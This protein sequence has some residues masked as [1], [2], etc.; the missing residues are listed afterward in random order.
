MPAKRTTRS[1]RPRPGRIVIDEVTPALDGGA[2]PIKRVVGEPVV[3]DATI[4]ADGH[5]RL[6]CVV[7]HQPPGSRSW[8][9]A[10]MHTT[11][12]GLD[13]WQGS[14]TPSGVG[15]H[16]YRV[17][18]WIDELASWADAARRKLDDNQE[19][20]S[21]LLAGAG[22]VEQ[23]SKVA[24]TE[25]RVALQDAA[26]R[27]RGG[28]SNVVSEVGAS[29]DR[30]PDGASVLGAYR[31]GF[32]AAAAATS[33][34]TLDVRVE[35]D[36]AVFNTWYELFPRSW[37]TTDGQHGTFKDVEAQL[38]Y[39][40]DLG[41]DVLYLPPIHPIG[42]SFRKGPG[43]RSTGGPDDPGSPWAIGSPEG[44]HTSI[45]PRLGTLDDFRRLVEAARDNRLDIA[46]D[47]AF[48]CSPD[49]PWVTEHPAWFEHRP[50]G[51]I[52]HAEN[53]PKK[54]QDIYPLDFDTGEWESLWEAL[55]DVFLYWARQG[56]TI[57]RVD[58]PH[59]KPFAFWSWVIG[60]VQARYPEAIFLSE[61]FTR[62]A[63]MHRLAKVGFTLSYSYFPWRQSKQEL[64]EYFTELAAPPG[65]EYFRPSCWPNTPDI[66]TTQLW[67]A[68]RELFASRYFLAATLS[69]SIGIYGPAFELCENRDAGNGKEEYADSEKYELRQWD[70]NDPISIREIIGELNAYRFDQ[71]ALHTL[72]TLLFHHT[73][74]DALLAYSKTPHAGPS[75]D[76]SRP[77]V[78]TVLMVANLDPHR[79]Q[80]GF[81][82]LDPGALGVDPSRPYQVHDLIADRTFTWEGPHVYVEL[83]PH[84]QPG[85][86]FR[87][88]QGSER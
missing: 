43:N 88:T 17:L 14:F 28:D 12:P 70:R 13:R 15:L 64:T 41:F 87:V 22:I 26:T 82:D 33:K 55:L 80:G 81:V 62:P 24:S 10:P 44:G 4:Y 49:H 79:T 7:A 61:A 46:L 42:T 19:I 75:V 39:V 18:A 56:V 2:F 9:L 67:G 27:L 76:P 1:K 37:S 47:I 57:F 38:A 40:A 6:W 52:Q 11:N 5:D 51:T 35:P 31:A 84:E 16:R 20:G 73:D 29:L 66:L 36:R 74:N 8:Q 21:D 60:E 34:P 30:E 45:H 65:V 48:Q 69:P 68:P 58:N 25:H 63:I 71:L 3:V 85:H 78:A 86:L 59:T 32:K 83:D 77:H 50:D 23:R 54:Y 72:R 53:P